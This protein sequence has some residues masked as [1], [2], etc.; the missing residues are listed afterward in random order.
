MTGNDRRFHGAA[1]IVEARSELAFFVEP[2][3][4]SIG[5]L[6]RFWDYFLTI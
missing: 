1:M 3:T 4:G 5:R 6:A 2:D